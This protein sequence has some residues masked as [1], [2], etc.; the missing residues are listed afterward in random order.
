MLSFLGIPE[1]KP[2]FSSLVLIRILL[3]V[4]VGL[5]FLTGYFQSTLELERKNWR[6]Q[7]INYQ[8]QLENCQPVSN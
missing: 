6:R 8:R 7:E 5:T 3:V 2:P 4:I 1:I